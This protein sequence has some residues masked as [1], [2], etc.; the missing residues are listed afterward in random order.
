M[1]EKRQF[2]YD[3]PRPGLTADVVL[4]RRT[5][6]AVEMLLVRR[7]RE[8]YRGRWA[9]PGGFVEMDEPLEDAARR[10]LEEETGVTGVE[11]R[12]LGAFGAPDRDPR[13][14]TVSIAYGAIV[15]EEETREG[16]GRC[17]G[18]AM[19]PDRRGSPA[20]FRSR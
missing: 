3:H 4:F 9:F 17:R 18:G 16:W 13:G 12:Q 19:V 14:R 20:G 11:L 8:P 7:D 5:G 6:A 15:D 10:E 1:T 2:C